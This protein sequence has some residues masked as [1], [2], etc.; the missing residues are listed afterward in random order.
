M[1]RLA[2]GHGNCLYSTS[3]KRA[4]NGDTRVGLYSCNLD[5]LSPL[6]TVFSGP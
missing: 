3:A 2:P 6:R 5:G 1:Q 4:V